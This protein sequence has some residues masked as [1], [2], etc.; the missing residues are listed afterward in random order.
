MISKIDTIHTG[1]IVSVQSFEN[2][3]K[4]VHI[5]SCSAP[6]HGRKSKV[7]LCSL[8]G[9]NEIIFEG[10]QSEDIKVVRAFTPS[11]DENSYL[12]AGE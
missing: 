8:S 12:I 2:N 4:E 6:G 3:D 5:V 7:A 1:N 9:R 11:W 10:F